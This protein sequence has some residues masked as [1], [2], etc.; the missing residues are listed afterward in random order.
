MGS[1]YGAKVLVEYN[2][3]DGV[4]L[5]TD[6]CT[7]PAKESN[8]SNLQGSV[9]GY[10][11][12]TQN[13]YVNRPAKA[14]DPYPLSNVQYTSY[15]GSTITPL[16]YADFA[17]SYSYTV[18][19]AEDVP[20]VVKAGAG[21]GKLGWTEA[22]VAVNNGDI[23]EFNGTDDDPTNP[24]QGDEDEPGDQPAAGLSEG[25][26]WL[27]NGATTAS[28]GVTSTGHLTISST[29]KWESGAQSFGVVYR[30]F[31][32]DFTATVKLVSYNPQST[33]N[34]AVAGIFMSP[35]PSASAKSLLF[36]LCGG[37]YF[38]RFRLAADANGSASTLGAPATT[39]SD[40][41]LRLV[42]EG[43]KLKA[44]YSLD[45]GTT[46]GNVSSKEFDS[47]PETVKLGLAVNS[48]N[49]STASTAEFADFTVNE[50][51]IAF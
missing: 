46:F 14:K 25:W 18:T 15:G 39:G 48:G 16:T 12:P 10:L 17:P 50:S 32:G 1:A 49:N 35:D 19:A 4:Q 22:P 44:S 30:D 23:T 26:N 45:G 33:N 37:N 36:A 8:E 31:T 11:Y 13:V 24:D 29:G 34:Q 6:I 43:N 9:A 47:L 28:Y 51:S 2:Y 41:V 5:P 7:Y 21:Y 42:R 27:N 3:F 38:A 40:V 20:T